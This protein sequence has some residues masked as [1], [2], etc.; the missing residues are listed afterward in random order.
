MDSKKVVFLSAGLVYKLL[1]NDPRSVIRAQVGKKSTEE[2]QHKPFA[3]DAYS[4][5]MN[6]HADRKAVPIVKVVKEIIKTL[7]R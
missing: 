2:M 5:V 3:G 6:T 4:P 7:W 1:I